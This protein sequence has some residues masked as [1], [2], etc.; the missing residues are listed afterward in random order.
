MCGCQDWGCCWLGAGGWGALS[1]LWCPGCPTEHT[2]P[3]WAQGGYGDIGSQLRALSPHKTHGH[4]WKPRAPKVQ[5][6]SRKQKRQTGDRP[7]WQAP[8]P[9]SLRFPTWGHRHPGTNIIKSVRAQSRL[10][11]APSLSP[12]S[13]QHPQPKVR[14]QGRTGLRALRAAVWPGSGTGPGAGYDWCAGSHLSRCD[15]HRPLS[16]PPAQVPARARCPYAQE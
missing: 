14:P 4:L 2:R 7:A 13:A 1:T 10:P 3:G 11:S 16:T 12:F 5:L 15:Q 8:E 9:R 6:R